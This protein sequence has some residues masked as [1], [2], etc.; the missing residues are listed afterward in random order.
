[1]EALSDSAQTSGTPL[2][3]TER[4]LWFYWRTKSNPSKRKESMKPSTALTRLTNLSETID[5]I[6][7]VSGV[8]G[9]SVGILHHGEILFTENFGSRELKENAPPTRDTVYGIGSLTKSFVAAGLTSLLDKEQN[10]TI[11][12]PVDKILPDLYL[13]DQSISSLVSFSDFLSHR[14]GLLGDISLVVQGHL[15]MLLEPSSLIQT[16]NDLESPFEFRRE[17]SYNNWGYSIAGAA[18]EKLSQKSLHESLK[19]TV[20]DPLGSKNTT[21]QPYFGTDGNIALG[22]NAISDGICYEHPPQS[23]FQGGIFEAAAGLY[24][25]VSD[26]LSYSKSVLMAEQSPPAQ[27]PLKNIS[28]L[29]S[30]QIPLENPSRDNR[31]Y[32]MGWV[33][34]ELPGI[35]GQ[36]GDNTDL[37][38]IDEL[39]ILGF[40]APSQMVYY[41]Q[42]STIGYYSAILLFPQTQSAVVVLTNSV[43]F[44]DAPDW[45]SQAYTA[46]LFD[47][48]S[49]ADYLQLAKEARGRRLAQF[50]TMLANLD[51]RRD[52]NAPPSLPLVKY[53]GK[54][55]NKAQSFFID[56]RW[57][58]KEMQSLSIAFQ[59]RDTQV[60]ELRHLH[61]DVFEWAMSYDYSG[62][63]GRLPISD[64]EYFLIEFHFHEASYGKS[65]TWAKIPPVRPDG[66]ALYDTENLCNGAGHERWYSFFINSTRRIWQVLWY[67]GGIIWLGISG[68]RT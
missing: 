46:A 37:F 40:G 28:L 26:L 2:I 43:P 61:D 17:W 53:L 15:E 16:V 20:L 29:I 13:Q 45:I 33:R 18:I 30:N 10:I 64:P 14:S 68:S 39:P 23:A 32:G 62:R 9:A 60:Y 44:S 25:T 6:C 50:D 7:N 58:T 59:G 65:L 31:F 35:V 34:T 67:L 48:P 8:V 22:H 66:L 3:V 51:Q 52:P 54:Y 42:G 57:R 1:M 41:H 36:Q 55:Y 11:D 38:E 47:F 12:T 49:P 19:N 56:V 4:A 5:K 24:S 21:T 27:G 63:R